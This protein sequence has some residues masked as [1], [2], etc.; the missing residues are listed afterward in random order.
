MAS[1]DRAV[2][3]AEMD[4]SAEGVEQDLDLDVATA[5]DQPLEDQAVV[6]ERS[7]CLASRRGERVLKAVRVADR[8]A[9]LCR[10]RRPPA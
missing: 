3:L 5:F 7:L 2:P 6:T 8:C 4:A 1:L 9:S 10:R